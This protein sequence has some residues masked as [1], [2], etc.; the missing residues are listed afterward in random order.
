MSDHIPA[1]RF[2]SLTRLYDGVL[3]VA[4]RDHHFRSVLVDLL[5]LTVGSRVLDL[6]CGTGSTTVL[7]KERFPKAAVSGVDADREALE[8]AKRKAAAKGLDIEWSVASA[9]ALPFSDERFDVI[10]ST[11][12]FHHLAPFDKARALFECYRVLVP[13]GQLYVLDW[14]KPSNFLFRSS[15]ALVQLLD[16][17]GNTRDHVDG[18]F[19]ELFSVAG[20]EN[21]LMH[22]P[23]NTAFGT[24]EI[25]SAIK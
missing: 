8:I 19:F 2:H 12:M 25:A 10:V 22:D 17:F 4:L 21:V 16:G 3:R 18:G 11:L 5:P 7:I 15:F 23:V 24:L 14:G 6:G 13:S 9:I 20:F 1:L